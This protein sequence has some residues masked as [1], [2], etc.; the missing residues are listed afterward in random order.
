MTK[1][2]NY[3]AAFLLIGLIFVSGCAKQYQRIEEL[4]VNK[5]GKTDV[6]R[7]FNNDEMEKEVLK[8]IN[9]ETFEDFR[10]SDNVE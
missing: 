10:H 9:Y 6:I 8:S 3:P 1:Y 2:K 5:D 7:Y 4:D